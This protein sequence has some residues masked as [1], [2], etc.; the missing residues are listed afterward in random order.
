MQT[1]NTTN[2]SSAEEIIARIRARRQWSVL[3]RPPAPPEAQA[4]SDR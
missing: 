2:P 3:Q 4:V 1:L